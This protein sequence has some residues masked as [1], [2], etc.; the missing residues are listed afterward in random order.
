M[1]YENYIGII[2]KRRQMVLKSQKFESYGWI[3]ITIRALRKL[4][5]RIEFFMTIFFSTTKTPESAHKNYQ[6]ISILDQISISEEKT[7]IFLSRFRT[8]VTYKNFNY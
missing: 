2:P 5:C 4:F 6:N 1:E 7:R 3:L 8:H